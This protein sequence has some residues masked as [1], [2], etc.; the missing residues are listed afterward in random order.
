MLSLAGIFTLFYTLSNQ[1]WL[2]TFYV[3]SSRGALHFGPEPAYINYNLC[4]MYILNT[5]SP[6]SAEESG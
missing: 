4:D 3:V 2:A 6:P 1:L 5:P